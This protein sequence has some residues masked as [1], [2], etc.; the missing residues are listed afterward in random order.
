MKGATAETVLREFNGENVR[1]SDFSRV[2][3]RKGRGTKRLIIESDHAGLLF[4]YHRELELA[5]R[6]VVKKL[7]TSAEYIE[8]A[9][10]LGNLPEFKEVFAQFARTS[11]A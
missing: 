3:I 9:R 2:R 5:I 4:R 7:T 8:T 10:W 6:S 11:G 1:P